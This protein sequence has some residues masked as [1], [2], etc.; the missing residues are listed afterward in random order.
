MIYHFNMENEKIFKNLCNLTTELVGLPEGSLAL[1]SR[2]QM[3]QVPRAVVSVIALKYDN[4]HQNI[5]SKV[6]DRNRSL[7]Y[8]YEK[9]H[10]ANF[11]SYPKYRKL[12]TE[13]L[14]AYNEIKGEQKT[15]SSQENYEQFLRDKSI[16][17][18]ETY[19][20]KISLKVGKFK[21]DLKYSHKD[22][23]NQMELIKLALKDY[24]YDLRVR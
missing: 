6:L 10:K 15:F 12:Y 9:S 19:Q 13:V 4:I 24:N 7:I 14:N 2:K 22:F 16:Y 18:S 23:Y 1:K 8:H 17:S 11:K 5:I 21:V 20:V 3:Y